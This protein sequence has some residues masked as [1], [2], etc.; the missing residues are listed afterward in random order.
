MRFCMKHWDSFLGAV[1]VGGSITL[2]QYNAFMGAVGV[3]L[4]VV[5]ISLRIWISWKHRHTPPKD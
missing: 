1:G 3:T 5:F 4:T 2:A